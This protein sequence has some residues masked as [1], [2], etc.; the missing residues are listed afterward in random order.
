MPNSPLTANPPS[1]VFGLDVS[2]A[3]VTLHDFATGRTDTFANKAEVLSSALMACPE[4][5]LIICEA[6]GGYERTCLGVALTLGRNIHRADAA[7]IKAFMRSHGEHAKTDQRDACWIARYGHERFATLPLWQPQSAAR[8]AL[9]DLVRYRSDL[10][11]QKVAAKNRCQSPGK[12]AV[13]D[14]IREQIAFLADQIKKIETLIADTVKE[15]ADLEDAVDRLTCVQGFGPV[16]AHTLLAFLPQLGHMNRKQA[17]SLAGLAPHTR[18]SGQWV[19]RGRMGGGRAGLRPVLFMAA[20]SA[21]RSHPDLKDF[22]QRLLKAGK[23]K[24]VA[25]GAVARKLVTIANA[26]LRQPEKLT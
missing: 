11:A 16:T 8:E 24:R 14:M 17:A 15:D 5:G 22:Y 4:D 6:T 2:K 26:V 1:A 3:T 10:V 20:L 19:G 12:T 21:A 9:A 23:P 13:K 25:L 7:R 18:Q